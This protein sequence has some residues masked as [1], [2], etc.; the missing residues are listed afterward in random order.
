MA[1]KCTWVRNLNGAP[2]PLIM[3]GKC[4][5][6]ATETLEHGDLC[7]LDGTDFVKLATDKA[8]SAE[9]AIYYGAEV[10]SGDRAGYRPFAVPRDGDVFK[11]SRDADDTDDN[12]PLG[13]AVYVS[14]Q[15]EVTTVAG[16]NVLGH[17]ADDGHIPEQGHLTVDAAP[18]AGTTLRALTEYHITIKKSCS[19][20][21]ALQA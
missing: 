10:K 4:K 17:I 7:E 14:A 21:A 15:N 3:L 12:P 18:D 2:G 16:T 6:G 19:Y 20:Y 1:A 11:M 13:T 5:A 8:M 9:V